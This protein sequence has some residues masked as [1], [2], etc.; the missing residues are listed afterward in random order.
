M[1]L[2]KQTFKLTAIAFFLCMTAAYAQQ[3]IWG[4]THAAVSAANRIP[5]DASALGGPGYNS[6]GDI[7]N[8][9]NGDCTV[10]INNGQITCTKANGISFATV[11]TSGS[12]S[13]LST[14]TLAAARLPNPSASTLGG[15]ESI[16]AAGSKWINSI[17]TSGVP[18]QTQ[19]NESDL[20]F[21]DI[22]TSNSSTSKHG[23]LKKL[24][25]TATQ[26]M[27]GTGS[28]ST[29][30]GT[31]DTNLTGPI[32][33]VGNVTSVASQTGTG[34]TFV[35]N[36]GPALIAPALGTPASGNMANVSGTATS[37][38]IGGNAGTVSTISGLIAA[39]TNVTITGAGT[40]ASPATI[41]SSG[42]GGG[43]GSGT[44]TSVTFTGDGIVDS[45][46]PSTTVT[47][48]GTVA[49]TALTQTANTILAGPASG[50]A[51]TSAFRAL[52]SAD[53][54]NNAANTSG[55][56]GSVAAA[57]ITGTTLASSVTASSIK[58]IGNGAAL[59]TPTSIVLT[60]A[61][62]TA[63]ALNIGGNAVTVTNGI[64]NT[65]TGTVTN[66]MLAGSIANAKL[67]NSSVTVN[68][69]SISLG[70]SGTV[71]AAAGTLT[72]TTLSS[73]VTTSSIPCAGLSN[74]ATGC[75]TS[76]GT[77]GATLPLLNAAN[78]WSAGQSMTPITL[79]ISGSTFT[80]IITGASSSNNN[81]I[82]LVHASC[83]CT[84]ANPATVPVGQSGVIVINQSTTG[85]DLI[86]TYGTDYIFTNGSAPALSTAANATDVFSYYNID[87][88]HI[89]IALLTSTAVA[90]TAVSA[91]PG[92]NVTSVTCASAACTNLRGT[93]TIVGGTATT[94]TI[95]SLSWTATPTAYVCTAT[96]NG[97]A[98]AFGIGNSVATTTGMNITAGVSVIGATF[99]VN[100]SCQ[101]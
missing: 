14:G 96:M 22:V 42:S 7:L 66:T 10:N 71:T 50:S 56:A 24:T 2:L 53:I 51:A 101:P 95:A 20:A 69:T 99:S 34:S 67:A 89:R 19:P 57:N 84:L 60:N 29:P 21:T 65:D 75:S 94:G 27:D 73:S 98:S 28:W 90:G 63:S 78:A 92:T 79:T 47:T 82:T 52:V 40:L 13:D 58:S 85:S 77:S 12:A 1:S 3:T 37:L 93:Y 97:G 41:S 38:N 72:G 4:S 17:S 25:G 45:S 68:G 6:V 33:S 36:N 11:A 48:S 15:I 8:L 100:Y 70:A 9:I 86:N 76:V 80:P 5:I 35:M 44:V 88:T 55:S 39:G 16:T 87:T 59:Q 83:P 18:T 30:A 64:Y 62:G 31:G 61:T 91:T 26:Y 49:A 32:T 23:F 46:T 54:P 43:G 74:G 81:N